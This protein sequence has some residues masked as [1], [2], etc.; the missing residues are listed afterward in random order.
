MSN[1]ESWAAT[2][3]PIAQHNQQNVF[4]QTWGHLA[5]EKNKTYKCKVLFTIGAYQSGTRSLVDTWFESD[6]DSSPWLYDALYEMINSLDYIS[7]EGVYLIDG[8]FRNFRWYGKAKIIF[9]L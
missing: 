7:K 3:A 9:S 4:K 8:S 1:A 5:P 2:F 6:L